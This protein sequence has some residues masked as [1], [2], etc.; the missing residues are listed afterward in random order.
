[1]K[2]TV[3]TKRKDWSVAPIVS[4]QLQTGSFLDILLTQSRGHDAQNNGI[5]N[6]KFYFW[7]LLDT[8]LIFNF[9]GWIKNYLYIETHPWTSLVVQWLRLL[10]FHCRWHGLIPGQGSSASRVVRTHTHKKTHPI[11]NISYLWVGELSIIF[12]FL[13]KMFFFE[14]KQKPTFLRKML[15]CKSINCPFLIDTFARNEFM[16]SYK[17][18]YK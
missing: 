10:C 17:L 5:E 1:M 13:L 7:S 2:N 12:I 16:P 15:I 6:I 11:T 4:M 14:G 8:I 18:T 3:G 9:G